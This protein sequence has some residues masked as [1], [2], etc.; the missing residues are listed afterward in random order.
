VATK[1]A[2]ILGTGSSR[3]K[4]LYEDETWGVNGVYGHEQEALQAGRPYRMDKLFFTDY[5]FSVEGSLHFN[6]S[7]VNRFAEKYNTQVIS[8]HKLGLGKYKLKASLYPYKRI[9]QKFKTTYF[10]SS[11]CYMLAY[12]LDKNYLNLKM[13]GVD[14]TTKSEYLLQK[15]AIEYWIGRIEQAGGNVWICPGSTIMAPPS[16]FP[17]GV[18]PKYN[19]K[20]IDP[21]NLLGQRSGK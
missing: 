20:E 7:R 13:Y 2:I 21:Y 9:S 16:A 19:M 6:I 17:Y 10:T 11:I 4:C 12:A 18:R 5:L 15:A 8:L 1:D 14:M 3:V